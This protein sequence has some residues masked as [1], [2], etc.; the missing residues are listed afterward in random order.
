MEEIQI[1]KFVSEPQ[2]EAFKTC[3]AILG[4]LRKEQWTF[5]G[6]T[7][8][9]LVWLQHRISLDLNFFINDIQLI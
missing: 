9:S 2:K 4:K 1:P 5:G 7:A 8:L 3:L 6:G